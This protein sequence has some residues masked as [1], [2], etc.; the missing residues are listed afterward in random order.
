M[1]TPLAMLCCPP[2]QLPTFNRAQLDLFKLFRA[3]AKAGGFEAVVRQKAW[4]SPLPGCPLENSSTPA[5]ASL[6]HSCA[7]GLLVLPPIPCAGAH[8]P[9]LQPSLEHDRPL[10]SDEE[11]LH[12]Q[13]AAV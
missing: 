7:H 10:I 13:A 1:S 12:Q 11:D 8:R 6:P 5:S 9:H 4:V 2:L 3:V